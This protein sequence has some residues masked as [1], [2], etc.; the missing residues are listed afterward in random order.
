M[1]QKIVP[2]NLAR[3][4]KIKGYNLPTYKAYSPE[5]N[6][7]CCGDYIDYN[8][9]KDILEWTSAPTYNEV[10]S[11][12]IN[13]L[14]YNISIVYINQLKVWRC[15]WKALDDSAH[16]SSEETIRDY[17]IINLINRLYI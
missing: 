3:Q 6:I 10:L 1:L 4:L 13:D 12:L 15:T 8:N 5:G 17:A 2:K 9:Y 16:I 7:Y 14:L 11:Y